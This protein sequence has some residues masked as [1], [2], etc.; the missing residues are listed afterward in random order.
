[1]STPATHSAGPWH[2][3]SEGPHPDIPELTY[4]RVKS[5]RVRTESWTTGDLYIAFYARPADARLIAASPDLKSAAADAHRA[6]DEVLKTLA[7]TAFPSE[8]Q[9]TW[10]ALCDAYDACSAALS[11]AEG[12]S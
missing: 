1:V 3:I 9:L 11:K 6:I 4:Y 10:N 12:R 2:A 7:E 5:A 8:F